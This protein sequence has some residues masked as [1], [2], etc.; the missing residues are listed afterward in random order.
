MH[1]S[2]SSKQIHDALPAIVRGLR[3]QGFRTTP[4]GDLLAKYGPD[5]AGCIRVPRR[6][7]C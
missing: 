7:H 6:K 2:D 4:V 3:Q 1:A 5:P